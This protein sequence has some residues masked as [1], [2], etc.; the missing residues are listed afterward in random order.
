MSKKLKIIS[1]IML[2][3]AIIF[4]V[5][6]FVHP[7]ASWPWGNEITYPLYGIYF[8]V[9]SSLFILSLKK[10]QTKTKIIIS[11]IISIS[12]IILI[13]IKIYPYIFSPDYLYY[14]F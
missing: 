2:I 3:V 13:A 7:E 4:L 10:L 9:M 1:L 5:L 8:M 12:I 11:L 6:A 14:K